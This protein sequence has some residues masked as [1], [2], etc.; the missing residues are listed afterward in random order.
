MQT[1]DLNLDQVA[2]ADF[3]TQTSAEL[4]EHILSRYHDRHR[5]QLPELI[6]LARRVEM[7][8]GG[9]SL[10][11]AGLSAVLE[12]MQ[13]ELEA[14]MAKEE[15]I[16]FPMI[17][18]GMGSAASMPVA[19]MRQQHDE[20]R[21]LLNEV[22]KVTHGITIPEDACNTWSSLYRGLAELRTDLIDHVDLE[23][24]VLFQRIDA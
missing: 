20:H 11:P 5:Q 6:H 14:H 17:I 16:L 24:N 10:C 22:D 21:N 19:M 7:V 12:R 1:L 9:H 13:D 18:R 15:Q 4:I 23:N 8:H 2:K 3:N